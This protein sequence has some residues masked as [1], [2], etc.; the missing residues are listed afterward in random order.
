MVAPMNTN[1]SF[2]NA[3]MD[4]GLNML[5]QSPITEQLVVSPISILLALA[6][7]QAGARGKTKTEINQV[8]S[9]GATDDMIVNYYSNLSKNVLTSKHEVQ[10]RIANA[11]FL[12]K[13]FSIEKHF[14][15][16]ITR[17]YEAKVEALDF[18]SAELTAQKINNFVSDVTEGKIKDVITEDTVKDTFSLMINAIYFTAKWWNAFD[19]SSSRNGTFHSSANKQKQIEYMNEKEVNRYYVEDEDMQALSLPYLDTSYAFNILLPRKR[20]ALDE[21]RMKLNGAA[22]RRVLSQLKSTYI[23][24]G[25]LR[26]L[27]QE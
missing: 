18:G 14:V 25:K 12:N 11:F 1:D 16:T 4:F 10:T 20:F 26:S 5:R 27:S 21:L 23:S 19:R 3:E 17:N 15:D 9:N 13:Q 24:V 2:L 8:I 7:V 6:M 22:I